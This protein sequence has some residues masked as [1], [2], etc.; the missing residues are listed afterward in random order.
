MQRK[1]VD[2]VELEQEYL[3]IVAG[4]DSKITRQENHFGFP[5]FRN[6]SHHY[7]TLSD[8]LPGATQQDCNRYVN[9]YGTPT[10]EGLYGGGNAPDITHGTAREAHTGFALGP[11]TV[12]RG[13]H[14]DGN[15]WVRNTTEPSHLAHGTVTRECVASPEGYRVQTDGEGTGSPAFDWTHPERSMG[16]NT[17]HF[18]NS[19]LAPDTFGQL[20]K[21]MIDHYNEAQK[22]QH[23]TSSPD[24]GDPSGTPEQ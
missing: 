12:D 6:A 2:H 8:P 24:T 21:N 7:T 17:R 14:D 13:V 19:Q 11:V 3:D 5:S 16:W 1:S 9:M 15:A 20:D 4:G 22:Y 18:F 23:D 10:T